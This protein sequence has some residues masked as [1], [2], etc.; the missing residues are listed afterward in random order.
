MTDRYTKKDAVKCA[1]RLAI[2]L[3]AKQYGNCAKAPKKKG[4]STTFKIG[5]WRLDERNVIEVIANKGGGISQPFGFRRRSNR[6]FCDT[7]R[8]VEDALRYKT[9]KR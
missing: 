4:G 3:K 8:F 6:D 2:L 5:C 9:R 7:V 1:R